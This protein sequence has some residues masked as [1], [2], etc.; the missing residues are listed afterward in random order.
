VFDIT[1]TLQFLEKFLSKKTGKEIKESN[2]S[3]WRRVVSGDL[4]SV[5]RPFNG[6]K[7]QLPE[8]VKKELFVEKIN[9]AKFKKLPS[10]YK[11]L[12]EAEINQV[13]TKPFQ[14]SLLPKQEKGIRDSCALPYQLNVD[15]E[16]SSDKKTFHI[17]FAA[18]KEIFGE[19]AAG[20]PFSIYAPGKYAVKQEITGIPVFENVKVWNYAVKAGDKLNGDWPLLNFENGLYHLRVYG[21]NGFF[22]EFSGSKKDPEIK[23]AIGYERKKNSNKL[24]G[25]ITLSLKNLSNKKQ[26]IEI[27][28]TTYKRGIRTIILEKDAEILQT[29][30]LSGS[31]NWYDLLL[32]VKGYD[33][34]EKRYAGRVETGIHSKSDPVMGGM[35]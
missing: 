3:D 5:F 34:F 32:K 33:L 7:I 1:S 9:N 6:E 12:T 28:D 11:A 30:D 17:S 19:H 24:T 16:L 27:I 23:I 20:A 29:F 18:G 25:N 14:S 13:K 26:T 2:I 8:F 35:I 10:D 22:R 21:P 4:T 15:G 31:Y